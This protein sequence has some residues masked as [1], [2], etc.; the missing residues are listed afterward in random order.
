MGKCGGIGFSCAIDDTGV[1]CW[2]A[3]SVETTPSL[4]APTLVDAGEAYASA[5]DEGNVK[6]W[7][8]L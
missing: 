8:G 4:S 3:D 5:V 6:C 1:V 7:D 2:G